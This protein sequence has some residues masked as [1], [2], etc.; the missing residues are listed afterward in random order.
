MEFERWEAHCEDIWD[1]YELLE[2]ADQSPQRAV[3][4]YELLAEWARAHREHDSAS[5]RLIRQVAVVRRTAH[6]KGL[7]ASTLIWLSVAVAATALA[8]ACLARGF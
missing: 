8:R 7:V 3:K 2:Q 1:N 6:R 5:K 4:L